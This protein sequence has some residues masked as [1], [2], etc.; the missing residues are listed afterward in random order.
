MVRTFSSIIIATLFFALISCN[1][2]K[3]DAEVTVKRT[4]YGNGTLKDEQ[5]FVNDTTRDGFYKEYYSNGKL[6]FV[7]NYENGKEHGT[8]K[9]YYE[10]GHLKYEMSYKRGLKSGPAVWYF[11]NGVMSSQY[12]Y[13]EDKPIGEVFHYYP[14]G[15]IKSYIVTDFSGNMRYAISY[16]ENGK[17]KHIG[18]N[19][20]A[21]IT[22]NDTNRFVVGDTLKVLFLVA[23]PPE[24]TFKFYFFKDISNP[25]T[26][27]E[28]SIDKEDSLVRF[29]M[30]L[31]KKGV[32][33]WGGH[34]YLR[35]ASGEE[36][37]YP[38]SGTSIVESEITYP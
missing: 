23:T 38:F 30:S 27:K 29:K 7:T 36:E 32:Y 16:G 28:V 11:E 1:S 25:M 14:S 19:G 8:K 17:I 4:Y 13:Y 6:R 24:A 10:N 31:D 26:R 2:K 37:T 21:G 3:G 34:L 18:G 22:T 5:S 12:N 20:V 9:G 15:K 35:F 33:K